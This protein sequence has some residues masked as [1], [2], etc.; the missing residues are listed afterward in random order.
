[1]VLMIA[2]TFLLL[3]R[4]PPPGPCMR[5]G[6]DVPR[7]TD[8]QGNSA[9]HSC[10]FDLKPPPLIPIPHP[11]SD[12]IKCQVCGAGVAVADATTQ[13][14]HVIDLCEDC[15]KA[16]LVGQQVADGAYKGDR[17]CR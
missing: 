11:D 6:R 16:A 1:M 15:D 10:L 9:C 5:C 17:W 14:G 12:S 8:I 13:E 2:W 7:F 4:R 3:P